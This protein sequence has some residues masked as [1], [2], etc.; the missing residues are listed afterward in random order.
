M[1]GDDGRA[2]AGERQ[3]VLEVREGR[4]EAAEQARHPEGHPGDLAAGLE[5]DRLD[6]VRDEIGAPR[7]SREPEVRRTGEL[8]Q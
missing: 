1:H 3:R 2:G 6:P 7:D 4:A 8:A 5:L